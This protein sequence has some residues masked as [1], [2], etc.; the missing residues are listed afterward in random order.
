MRSPSLCASAFA[1]VLASSLLVA[2]PAQAQAASEDW[3]FE[4]TMYGWVPT[5][6]SD[7]SFTTSDGQTI[8]VGTSVSKGDVLD[9]L[10]MAFF[11]SFE[12]KKGKYGFWT[13]VAYADLGGM[14]STL[15]QVEGGRVPI[16]VDM[17]SNLGLDLKTWFWTVA[18]TYNLLLDPQYS[19]DLVGG[20]R[21]LNMTSTLDY[22]FS[23]SVLGHP[24]GG[25]SGS[26][27]VS[28]TNWDA[29]VGV[30]G[31]AHF[32]DDRRWFV[33]YYVDVG[34]GQSQLTWQVSAGVGYQFDWG[35]VIAT[36]RYL[37]YDFKS[38]SK[39]ESMSLNGPTI[40]VAFRW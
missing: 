30:K 31:R 28:E 11:G 25:R 36:W 19:L 20:A 7:L 2:L 5:I 13:D 33:P 29:V 21:M 4:A 15:R 37:D 16:P 38:D 10:K 14:E 3:K 9:A 35:S 1:A 22:E 8:G 24:L 17:T 12:G 23:P 34:A 27:E 40:G 18:G 32:G 26:S 39:L 6:K